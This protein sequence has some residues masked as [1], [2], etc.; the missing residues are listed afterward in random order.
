M[1]VKGPMILDYVRLIRANRGRDWDRYLEPEDWKIVDSQIFT[2]NRYPYEAFRRIGFAVFKIIGG[3]DLNV[4]RGFGRFTMKNILAIYKDAILVPGEPLASMNKLARLRRTFMDG[5]ADTRVIES[6]PGWA[7]Y[8]LV[9][10]P[11]E[12]DQERLTAYCHQ[13]TGHLEE[14]VE[15]TGKKLNAA[16]VTLTD[17]GYQI[18]MK[19]Q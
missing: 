14:L 5:E 8:L 10:P 16:E 4:A 17:Q 3:G 7:R 15:Q 1:Y 13:L 19:W 6:G 12:K 9:T 18:L 11:E 2:T